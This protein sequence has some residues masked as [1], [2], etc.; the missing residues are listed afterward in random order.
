M[1]ENDSK[2]GS[3]IET[4]QS[5]SQLIT[6][7]ENA[8]PRKMTFL[9]AFS[10][11][12]NG[13]GIGLLLGILLSTTLSPVVSGV[14]ATVSSL[15][16]V[17]IGLNEKY[18]DPVKSLRIGSFGL[19][20]VAGIIAGLYLRANNPFAPTLK[21]KMEE[22]KSI[23]FSDEE[24][25]NLIIGF[26]KSD[27][28]KAQREASLL[29]STIVNSSDCDV[30]YYMTAETPVPE[31]VNTFRSTEGIWRKFADTF[32]TELPDEMKGKSLL[33][34]RDSFCNSSSSEPYTI[35]NTEKIKAIN[36]KFSLE[37]METQISASG[38]NWKNLILMAQSQ[39]SESERLQIY[40]AI[41]KVFE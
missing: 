25:R 31:M 6:G 35:S 13:L 22:Y 2:V 36:P 34:V 33:L 26:I 24:A 19:F 15:L 29:Y 12:F 7:G 16:A 17:L 30:L 18:L 38:E 4:F 27:T 21:D 14:I 8:E 40:K 5:G 3:I 41:L 32:Q 28:S 20:T 23:G 10:A 1:E 11:I 39:F 9:N 37:E